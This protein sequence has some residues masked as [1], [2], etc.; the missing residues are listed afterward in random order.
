[1]RH[2]RTL[3]IFLIF[4]LLSLTTFLHAATE[5]RIALVIGN[6]SYEASP[7]RNPVND[8]TDMAVSLKNLGFTVILRTNATKIDT[9]L[10]PLTVAVICRREVAIH[11]PNNPPITPT[12]TSPSNPEPPPR[13]TCPANQ[14]AIKPTTIHTKIEVV[15][16]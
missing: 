2:I 7:L 1:M 4:I 16:I 5:Q 15:V 3:Y 6:S 14:P 12:T 13:M 8:A 10:I 11:P 9:R